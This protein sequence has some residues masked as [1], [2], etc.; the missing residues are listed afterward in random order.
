LGKKE[1]RKE[2]R[3][4][5]KMSNGKERHGGRNGNLITSNSDRQT[6]YPGKVEGR[7]T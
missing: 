2:K 7:G 1:V 4:L 3:T 5:I 6:W